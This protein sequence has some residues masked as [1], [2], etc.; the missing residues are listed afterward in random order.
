MDGRLIFLHHWRRLS[1]SGLWPKQQ[2]RVRSPSRKGEGIYDP[3]VLGR[4]DKKS[5]CGTNP[6]PVLK[7]TQVGA[8]KIPRRSR[9]R[10]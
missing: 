7:P 1:T 2:R 3:E 8:M 6:V 9:E 10:W 5:R 4:T